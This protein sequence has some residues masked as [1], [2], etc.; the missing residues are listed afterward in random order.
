MHCLAAFTAMLAVSIRAAE[1]Q[2]VVSYSL[3]YTGAV[4]TTLEPV[5]VSSKLLFLHLFFSHLLAALRFSFP[6]LFTYVP[7][8]GRLEMHCDFKT[9]AIMFQP[10]APLPVHSDEK[11]QEK[12]VVSQSRTFTNQD[13]VCN[14]LSYITGGS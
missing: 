10:Y 6:H 1:A 3:A 2:G 14:L 12:K 7:T 13:S 8:Y 9:R 5:E 4:G 11:E